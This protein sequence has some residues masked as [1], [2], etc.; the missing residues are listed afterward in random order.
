MLCVQALILFLEHWEELCAGSDLSEDVVIRQEIPA[1]LSTVLSMTV[2]HQQQDGSWDSQHEVT[3]Y[4]ILTLVPLLSLPWPDTL[5]AKVEVCVARGREYLALNRQRWPQGAHLWIEKVTYA[6]SVLSQAY[7]LAA[8]KI[9]TQNNHLNKAAAELYGGFD[10]RLVRLKK[11]FSRLPLF[12]GVPTWRLDLSLFQS[13]QL[14]S[15]LKTSNNS[16]FQSALKA[17]KEEYLQYIPFTWI[18]CADLHSTALSTNDIWEMIIISM[19]NFQA[20]AF[21]ENIVAVSHR[22]QLGDLK[23]AVRKLC[24][25]LA[26]GFE[27][28]ASEANGIL[29]KNGIITNGGHRI[30]DESGESVKTP[31]QDVVDTLGRFIAHILRHPK[32]L[33]SSARLQSW[34]RIELEIF[35]VAHMTHIQDCSDLFD[36][37]N[38]QNAVLAF[39][40]VNTTYHNW[41]RTTGAAHTSCPFSFVF[42]LCLISDP[43]HDIMTDVHT[44]YVL[45]D[46]CRHLAASCRQYNDFGSVVRDREEKNLNSIN[47]PEFEPGMGSTPKLNLEDEK[48]RKKQLLRL[49]RYERLGLDNA[50]IELEKCLSPSFKDK[51]LLFVDVTELFGQIYVA[52]D[53]GIRQARKNS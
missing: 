37:V 11:F 41:V 10:A 30:S 36:S 12:S 21:M 23:L 18:G 5:Q 40:S 29:F 8:S 15:M 7:C 2:E 28:T 22:D 52:R 33:Q 26:P 53:I 45:E 39:K 43:D 27:S 24:N 31:F 49:A 4:A 34:L 17:I 44:R 14:A 19:L 46:A 16:I 42:Y 47:F 25:S 50:L 3:A 1:I 35:L 51:I 9:D 32:V 48:E 6:C 20:D 38:S 13:F